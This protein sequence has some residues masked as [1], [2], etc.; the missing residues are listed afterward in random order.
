MN[1]ID[2]RPAPIPGSMPGGRGCARCVMDTTDPDITFDADGVCRH[3]HDYDRLAAALVRSGAEGQREL[4]VLV[5][6]MR[7]D[8]AGRP[9]DCV[10]GVSG[11]VDSTFVAYQVKQ[12]GLRP[13]AA[14]LDNGWDSEIAATN[15]SA[16][17]RALDIDLETLVIDWEEFKDIQLAFLRSGV[18]DCEI[19]SDHAIMAWVRNVATQHR[20]RHLIWGNN[21]RTETH[22]PKAWSQG[23][24]DWR[25]IRSV[26]RRFGSGRIRTFPHM[27]FTADLPVDPFYSSQLN[28]LDYVDYV[29]ADAIAILERDVG[30]RSYG[31][32]HHENIYT[33][34]YQGWFLPTRFGYDKRKSHLS[35]L[36]CSGQISREHAERELLEPPYDEELQRADTEYVIK[37]LGL[38]ADGFRAIMNGPRRTF[39]DFPSY[40]ALRRGQPY[41]ISRAVYRFAK[42]LAGKS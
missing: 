33:R 31:G 35:S 3:C 19:P 10:I 9:Y 28:L 32:K 38:T 29:K 24:F 5:E 41:L 25:Y 12:L 37:K 15:I 21:T 42:S 11:G 2:F 17:L 13:I 26:H 34:W 7:R 30:W 14:H 18:P 23:H 6:R 8:G 16:A 20:V 36:I 27:T 40:A 22:L 39:H 1:A 4:E